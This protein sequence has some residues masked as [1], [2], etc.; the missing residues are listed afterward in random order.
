MSRL[1]K[2]SF[3][4]RAIYLQKA[5]AIL[6]ENIEEI[7]RDLIKEEG[8]PLSGGMG[9]ANRAVSILEYFAAEARQPLI[10]LW[11]VYIRALD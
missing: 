7:G 2:I 4:Q 1:E 11:S 6:K 5:A 8:K 10:I 9:E 3:Q